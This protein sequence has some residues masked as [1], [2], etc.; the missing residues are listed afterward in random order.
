MTNNNDKTKDN[1]SIF[2]NIYFVSFLFSLSL[3]DCIRRALDN[4]YNIANIIFLVICFFLI[5]KIILKKRKEKN[6]ILQH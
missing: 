5:I 6:N 1:K 3:F 2:L 4:T